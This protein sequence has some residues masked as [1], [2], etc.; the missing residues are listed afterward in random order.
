MTHHA[1]LFCSYGTA[2]VAWF[3]IGR[4]RPGLW[5]ASDAPRFGRP[6]KEVAAALIAGVAVIGM[7]QLYQRGIR[8][9]SAGPVGFLTESINQLFIFAPI[10]LL[11]ALR[12]QPYTTAWLP[13]TRL[14]ERI[15]CGLGMALIALLVFSTTRTQ[16]AAPWQILA[17]LASVEHVPHLMQVFFEDVAIAILAVRLAAALPRGEWT[18]P[19]LVGVLFAAGHVPAII[20]GGASVAQVALLLP[21]ALLGFLVVAVLLRAR[22]VWWFA[23]VHWALDMMQFERVSGVAF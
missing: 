10:L 8:L 4:L 9:P 16:A 2:L 18:V 13:R 20:S 6:W 3:L 7:G 11:P 23:C 12:R 5:P 14:P 17:A 22:D 1:A 19:A 15:G 21:D